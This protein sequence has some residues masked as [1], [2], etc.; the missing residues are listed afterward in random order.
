MGQSTGGGASSSG[1]GGGGGGSSAPAK[2]KDNG[3]SKYF[4]SGK[5]K[6][7]TSSTD[8]LAAAKKAMTSDAAY[9]TNVV[10]TAAAPAAKVTKEAKKATP[11][12]SK[13]KV[14]TTAAPVAKITKET[15]TLGVLKSDANTA[16]KSDRLSI[17]TMVGKALGGTPVTDV[18]KPKAA[19]TVTSITP[20]KT[21]APATTKKQESFGVLKSDQN[22]VAPAPKPFEPAKVVEAALPKTKKAAAVITPPLAAPKVEPTPAPEQES[23]GVLK[24]DQNKAVP[25]PVI[26]D[27]STAVQQMK[28]DPKPDL[29]VDTATYEKLAAEGKEGGALGK[30]SGLAGKII[31][32]KYRNDQMSYNQAYWASR[33]AAGATQAELAAEQKAIGM[34][35]AYSGDVVVTETMK[36]EAAEALEPVG[37]YGAKFTPEML[38]QGIRKTETE[39]SGLFGEHSTTKMTYAD[40]NVITRKATDPVIKTP[41][42]DVRLGDKTST[43]YANGVEQYTTKGTT[44]TDSYQDGKPVAHITDT[45]K[46]EPMD[47]LNTV[48]DVQE[49]IKNT[50]DAKQLAVL[51]K[52]LR[53]LMR[54]RRTQTRF[55]GLNITGADVE[56]TKLG[57]IMKIIRGGK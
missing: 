9:K 27:Y 41:L 8:A 1:G 14:T 46:I 12:I 55:G 37:G 28:P 48:A 4:A 35:K 18:T 23:F 26:K 11:V 45:T 34:K 56:A 3:T 6:T 38:T 19:T 40:G 21:P 31:S 32:D 13:P 33:L 7:T 15:P 2:K 49:A 10:K 43:V 25:T 54:A 29:P 42:G 36:R 52:R 24:S 51:H 17:D 16:V 22:E 50:T 53:S 47:G 44:A 57:G 20:T 30:V 39:T 5:K